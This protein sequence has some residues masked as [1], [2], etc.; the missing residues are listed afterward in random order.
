M[1]LGKVISCITK[2]LLELTALRVLKTHYGKMSSFNGRLVFVTC[3][4]L[5]FM[6]TLNKSERVSCITA[7]L[8]LVRVNFISPEDG[9]YSEGLEI[10]LSYLYFQNCQDGG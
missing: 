8:L 7:G 3:N 9:N 10:N 2:I 6:H 1:C 5:Y 4:N